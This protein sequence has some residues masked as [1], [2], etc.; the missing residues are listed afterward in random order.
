M[1]K[2]L[3]WIDKPEQPAAF[4]ENWPEFLHQAETMPALR[5]ESTS[6]VD[7]VL[8]GQAVPLMIHELF[9]D[10]L[11]DLH[12]AMAS[13]AGQLAGKTLQRITG[14]RVSL[15]ILQHTEDNLDHIRTY[16]G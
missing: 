11:P 1:F 7:S 5:R 15:L 12:A 14:G 9:F 6:R 13:Q 16:Q 10:S 2:L 4:E 8:F 3:I